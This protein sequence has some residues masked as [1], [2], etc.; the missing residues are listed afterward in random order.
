ML[1]IK[2]PK[3]DV[4]D[5]KSSKYV[6]HLY[7]KNFKNFM[8][9]IKEDVNKWGIS[10]Q[11]LCIRILNVADMLIHHNLIFRFNVNPTKILAVYFVDI[12]KLILKLFRKTILKKSKL[13]DSPY[14]I[15]KLTKK[16]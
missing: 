16:L 4:F 15:S 11:C 8:K 2:A 1:F 3:N 10:S 9:E 13:E 12:N 6:C 5:Y 14:H 7:V